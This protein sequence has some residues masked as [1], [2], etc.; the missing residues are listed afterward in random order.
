MEEVWKD[1]VGYEDHFRVS[2]L[3]RVTS[4]RTGKILKQHINKQGRAGF[5]T[6]I[7]GRNG[8]CVC[9]KTHRLVATAFIPNPENKPTV[10]HK[11]GNPLNNCVEN[12][13][14]ATH[15]ENIRHAFDTGLIVPASGFRSTSAKLTEEQVETIRINP[16]GLTV[17][18][19]AFLLGV[20]HCTVVRCKNNKRYKPL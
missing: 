15:S 17:R 19:L 7:G 9:F 3:G 5:A 12:L 13:E 20:H 16:D 8:S 10:N 11:D 14:W 4:K 2:N 18:Q 1:V 6:K